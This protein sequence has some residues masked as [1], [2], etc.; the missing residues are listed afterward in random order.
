MQLNLP[1]TFTI[2]GLPWSLVIDNDISAHCDLYYLVDKPSLILNLCTEA[3]GKPLSNSR[4][5]SNFYQGVVSII[6]KYMQRAELCTSGKGFL[7]PFSNLLRQVHNTFWLSGE[8][9]SGSFTLGADS[10][11]IE[12][13]EKVVEGQNAYGLCDYTYSKIFISTHSTITKLGANADHI[14]QICWHEILHAIL[15]TMDSKLSEDEEFV[16]IFSMLFLSFCKSIK[17]SEHNQEEKSTPETEVLSD[18]P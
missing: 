6:L 8:S 14:V 9:Y 2:C 15:D 17:Q 4:I 5:R 10:W 7:V 16:N 1:T 11:T 3:K 18:T 13:N 12:A